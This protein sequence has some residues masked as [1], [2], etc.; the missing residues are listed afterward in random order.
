MR[1]FGVGFEGLSEGPRLRRLC[2]SGVGGRERADGAVHRAEV[3]G[4]HL[5]EVGGKQADHAPIS[6][7]PARPPGAVAGVEAFDEVALDEAQVSF[8]LAAIGIDGPAPAW[9]ASGKR[10]W[11]GDHRVSTL[12]ELLQTRWCWR[13]CSSVCCTDWTAF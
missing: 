11:R 1:S 2:L 4:E 3:V 10:R 13:C 6:S 9:E 7:Q 12:W 5:D 8:R